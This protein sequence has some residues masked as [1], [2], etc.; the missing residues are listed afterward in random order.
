MSHKSIDPLLNPKMA[1]LIAIRTTAGQQVFHHSRY[2][3]YKYGRADDTPRL[4][5]LD[6]LVDTMP[7]TTRNAIDR[8]ADDEPCPIEARLQRLTLL[9]EQFA[10]EATVVTVRDGQDPYRYTGRMFGPPS[11]HNTYLLVFMTRNIAKGWQASYCGS[12][13][14][15]VPPGGVY[16]LIVFVAEPMSD[17][18]HERLAAIFKRGFGI[19]DFTMLR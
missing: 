5:T 13:R 10:E 2:L 8:L 6:A 15:Y 3:G 17:A 1:D 19:T 16:R 18:E 4:E 12:E 14:P 11:D 9:R 7:E